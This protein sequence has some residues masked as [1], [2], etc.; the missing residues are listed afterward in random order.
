MASLSYFKTT[1]LTPPAV[2]RLADPDIVLDDWN[3]DA[4]VR[5]FI[6]R[7]IDRCSAAASDYCNR[8]FGIAEYQ[9]VA[10]LERGYRDGHLLIGDISPLM[11]PYWPITSVVSVTETDADGTITTLVENTDFEVVNKVAK[12]YRLDS[13][14]R[15]RDWWP[16]KK[17]TIVC[18]AGYVLPG[19]ILGNFPGAEMLP[20]HLQDAIGRM[21]AT[22]YFER[23]RD[24]FL[25]SETVEGIMRIDY[26]DSGTSPEDGGNMSPDVIDILNNFR[27]PVLA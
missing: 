7:S 9:I 6:E 5:T 3:I 2:T 18:W 14:G 8:Q 15:Q 19:Q 10:N 1:V 4:S 22:R 26:R 17:V 24:P 20:A 21:V 23:S 27:Q 12:F 16:Q 13:Y 25:K 11:I